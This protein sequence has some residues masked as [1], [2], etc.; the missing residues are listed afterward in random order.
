MAS[1]LTAPAAV[2]LG[3]PPGEGPVLVIVPP[4]SDAPAVLAASGGRPLG[5]VRAPFAVLAAFPS[6][7]SA[8]QARAHGAWAVLGGA[9]LAA[10]CGVSDART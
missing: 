2:L 1:L 9:A 7:E 4:W 10:L 3:T 6:P 5:P 8:T